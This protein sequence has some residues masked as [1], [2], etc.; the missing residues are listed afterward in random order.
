MDMMSAVSG[1]DFV[2]IVA[3]LSGALCF[4]LSEK[5]FNRKQKPVAFFISFTMGII[6]ADVTLD[7]IND[8]IPGV[9][10]DQRAVGAFVCSVLIITVC[11]NVTSRLNNLLSKK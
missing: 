3:S 2:I 7:V 5:Q 11:I 9:Y 1:F 10:T 4:M 8:L 6:G